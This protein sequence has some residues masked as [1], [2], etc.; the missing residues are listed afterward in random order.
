MGELFAPSRH[1]FDVDAYYRMAETGIL[2][3]DARVELIDG[4][5][6]DRVPIGSEHTGTTNRLTRFFAGMAASGR[7]VLGVRSPLRIDARNE[8]QP[9]L[10]LLAPRADDYA[11]AHPTPADVLLPVE[12][13]ATS[14]AF[15]RDVKGPLY[16][17]AGVRELWLV[18]LDAGAIHLHRRPSGAGW[19]ERARH[20]T[21]PLAPAALPDAAIDVAALFD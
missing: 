17:L 13:A 2:P 9:D 8:P 14:L 15:D 10:M 4:E 7:A 21:G 1:R 11:H 18:D 6:L 3:R 12:V 19:R 20:T 5:V 16:A